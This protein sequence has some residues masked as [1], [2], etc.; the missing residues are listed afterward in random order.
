MMNDSA[1]SLAR[2]IRRQAG[3]V[4]VIALI[5]LMAM[6]LAAVALIRSVDTANLI[7]GNLAFQQAATH[8]ADAGFE[9][10][11]T[12]LQNNKDNN[13]LNDNDILNGYIANGA[14]EENNPGPDT[15]T[16]WD[17]FW[18][19]TL[20]AQSYPKG[21]RTPDAAGN[22]WRYVIHRMCLTN[23]RQ[24][25]AKCSDSPAILTASG[26]EEEGGKVQL[27]AFSPVYY[28]ITVRVDG[29]KNTVS[30]VQTVVS[31]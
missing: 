25:D 5:V 12:W 11:I 1:L 27:N 19:G 23:G 2:R 10:A 9:A 6:T 13:V 28:R 22:S 31:M 16:T 4:L 24:A 29:P 26:N 17:A 30:Y 18:S 7:A 20:A 8:S 3:V 15:G 21:A 14:A